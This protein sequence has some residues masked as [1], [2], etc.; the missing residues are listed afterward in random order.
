MNNKQLWSML[1]IL[2]GLTCLAGASFVEDS[3]IRH[4]LV[5]QGIALE[6]AGLTAFQHDNNSPKT[7]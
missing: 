2:L 3:D 1:I 7:S 6:A 4:S 5:E